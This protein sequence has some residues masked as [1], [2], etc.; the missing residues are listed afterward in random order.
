MSSE[1]FSLPHRTQCEKLGYP[2]NF[3]GCHADFSKPHGDTSELTWTFRHSAFD[4]SR[5]VHLSHFL[6]SW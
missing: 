6:R 5:E 3:L 1:K 2:R 4:L